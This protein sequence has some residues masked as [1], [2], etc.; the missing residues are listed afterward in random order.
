MSRH[1][2]PRIGVFV[3]RSAYLELWTRY[4][5]L[6]RD[7]QSLGEDHQ[8]VLEHHEELL[9][10]LETAPAEPEPTEVL[11]AAVRPRHVPSW[12]ETEEV[13]VITGL[14][15]DKADALVRNTGL[16]DDPSG[17][18]RVPGLQNG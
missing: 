14:D 6:L 3:R 16:L 5:D 17:E 4:Q 18:W 12:A 10:R 15:P 13:P 9:Y 11:P 7:Y 1:R 2:R 8:A